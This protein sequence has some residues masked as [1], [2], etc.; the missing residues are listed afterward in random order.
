MN[1]VENYYATMPAKYRNGTG[2]N[3]NKKAHDIEI[4]CRILI[5]AP[6]GGFKNNLLMDLLKKRFKATFEHVIFCVK[7]RQQPFYEMI[8]D[9][10]GDSVEFFD[11]NIP[12]MSEY[13]T[14]SQKLI[15]FDDYV[16]GDKQIQTQI[17]EYFVRGRHNHFSC[18]YLSQSFY[19]TPKLIRGNVNYIF[20]LKI[21]SKRD[22]SAILSEIPISV[23][24]IKELLAMY[25]YARKGAQT[26]FLNI[27]LQKNLLKKNYLEIL[28]S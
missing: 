18:I 28:R 6:S 15:I 25:E 3:P 22:L 27:D 5:V 1:S 14:E 17:S 21:A 8:E 7:N 11:N 13:D 10:M 4:P 24:D 16:M 2:H 9:K 26:N 23:N 20:L 12:D 19:K